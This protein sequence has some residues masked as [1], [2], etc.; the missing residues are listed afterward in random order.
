MHF[1]Y[2]NTRTLNDICSFIIFIKDLYWYT[3][4]IDIQSF[5]FQVHLKVRV[6]KG[7]RFNDLQRRVIYTKYSLPTTSNKCIYHSL[8]KKVIHFDV[9][10]IYHRDYTLFWRCN[11]AMQNYAELCCWQKIYKWTGFEAIRVQT[12]DI[13]YN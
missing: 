10:R 5:S 3:V 11:L 12:T 1:S 13:F 4:C 9:C 7:E 6:G 8:N 2:Q